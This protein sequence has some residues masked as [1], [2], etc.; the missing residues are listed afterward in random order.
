MPHW[1]RIIYVSKAT[2]STAG[3]A[4]FV[5]P[6]VGRILMQSRRNNPS[7]GLVG[8][9]Y[10]GDG[11]FF[12]CL[13]GPQDALDRLLTTLSA[14]PRHTEIK[15]LSRSAIAQASFFGWSMKYVP[16]AAEVRKLLAEFGHRQFNPYQFDDLQVERMVSL[17]RRE[18]DA[19]STEPTLTDAASRANH[20]PKPDVRRR[21]GSWSMALSVIALL[22]AIAALVVALAH[23]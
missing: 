1:Q 11:H 16:A 15:V 6:E 17:L 20:Q 18:A 10:Y 2:F 22:C 19:N 14:D 23:R 4:S 7:R 5:E 8:A 13:E 21:A 9:L 3:S 12:Q